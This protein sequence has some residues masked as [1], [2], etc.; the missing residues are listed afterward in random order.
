MRSAGDS[1]LGSGARFLNCLRCLPPFLS[2]NGHSEK[3]MPLVRPMHRRV[4]DASRT[5]NT[6]DRGTSFAA[7]VLS[8]SR[9]RRTS[10][11]LRTSRRRG[12]PHLT[13]SF[14]P[15]CTPSRGCISR[16]FRIQWFCALS[17]S[18]RS[19]CCS[20]EHGPNRPSPCRRRL[21]A[22]EG[23]LRP[24]CVV[25]PLPPPD[26]RRTGRSRRPAGVVTHPPCLLQSKPASE[27]RGIHPFRASH[28]R[29]SLRRTGQGAN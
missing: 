16:L 23:S 25:A 13:R 5:G 9:F 27:Y 3:T 8:G 12:P 2:E 7:E 18:G 10:H 14:H 6:R 15:G 4:F 24:V 26:G 21:S 28:Y 20:P 22:P 11:L 17:D 1:G 29:Q 19:P